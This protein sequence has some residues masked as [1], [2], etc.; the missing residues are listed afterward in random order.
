M[1]VR[2]A[3]GHHHSP[4]AFFTYGFSD[5]LLSRLR[6]HVDVIAAVGNVCDPAD[7]FGDRFDIDGPGNI[8]PA[9]AD[10]NSQSLHGSIFGITVGLPATNSTYE[11]SKNAKYQS[12]NVKSNPKPK[13][14]K[15]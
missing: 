13:S 12:S 11:H 4:Q 2:R 14:E 15:L 9:M 3:T 6:A 8:D 1:H 5:D 7:L 10:E